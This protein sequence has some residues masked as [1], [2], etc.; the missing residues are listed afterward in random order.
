MEYVSDPM[1]NPLYRATEEVDQIFKDSLK[2]VKTNKNQMNE[3]VDKR[4]P[5][6]RLW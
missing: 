3:Y 5:F 4:H 1:R 6:I 2:E